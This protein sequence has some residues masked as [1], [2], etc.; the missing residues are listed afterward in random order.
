MN[1]LKPCPFCGGEVVMVNAGAAIEVGC[2]ASMSLQKSD[3][4]TIAERTTWG[5]KPFR[6]SDVYEEISRCYIV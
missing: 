1:E 2:C 5:Q 6:Y 4:L 3:V